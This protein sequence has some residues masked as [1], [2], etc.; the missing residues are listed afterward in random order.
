[1]RWILVLAVVSLSICLS[2]SQEDQIVTNGSFED[3]FKGWEQYVNAAA[4]ASFSLEKGG[5]DG[6]ECV[7]V[8]VKKISG[9][10]WHIGLTQDSLTVKKTHT[11]TVAFFAKAKDKPK[12]VTVE[13][14]RSPS[15]GEWEGITEKDILV[16][17]DDWHEY[18]LTFTPNKDYDKTAFLGFWLGADDTDI[19]I[20]FVRFYEGKYTPGKPQEEMAVDSEGKLPTT[21]GEIKGR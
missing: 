19:W 12:T 18:Y 7:F 2:Y 4:S 13:V 1:M 17:E 5:V 11:Y 16:T 15:Q 9:T 10:N 20:D 3:G 8:D 21:W 6:A 14:K